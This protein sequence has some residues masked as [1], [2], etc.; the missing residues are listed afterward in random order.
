M[1]LQGLVI[2]LRSLVAVG[3]PLMQTKS[4]SA[5]DQTSNGNPNKPNQ[6]VD[7]SLHSVDDDE[8]TA[9]YRP[10]SRTMSMA[11]AI[12]DEANGDLMKSYDR[13]Q[14]TQEEIETGILKFN[15]SPKKGLAYLAS[16]GHVDHTPQGTARFFHQYVDKLDK[17]AIGD[18]LGREVEY[19]G[20]FCV[21]V[22]HEYVDMLEFENMLFDEAI[23][24]LLSGFRLPG[25]AQKI[26]RIMEKFAERYYLQNRTVFASADMAF[27]LAFSTIMLQTNLHNPAIRDDKRMTKEQF[28]RQNTGI[29]ADGELPIP[30]LSEIYDRIAAC[31]ISLVQDDKLKNKKKDE[32]MNLFLGFPV[33]VMMVSQDKRRVDAYN[34]ERK[35]MIRASEAIF[36][37]RR[38]NK[39]S[40][41]SSKPSSS[42]SSMSPPRHQLF[43]RSQGD[44]FA[45][46]TPMFEVAW[47]P[48]LSVFSQ[49]LEMSDEEEIVSL[50]LEGFQLSIRLACHCDVNT[51]RDTYITSLTKF[52][53]LEMIKE[54]KE[55]HIDGIKLLIQVALVEGDYLHETWGQILRC[56]SHLSRLQLFGNGVHSDDMFFSETP[57]NEKISLSRRGFARRSMDLTQPATSALDPF[58][59][60]STPSKAETSRL[61]E[62]TNAELLLR[63]IDPVL[64]DRIFLNSQNLST[65]SVLFFVN[66]LC[67]V[68]FEEISSSPSTG[69]SSWG[70]VMTS[71]RIFCLQKLVEVA[72]FN[73]HSRPRLAWT[74]LWSVLA[75]HFTTVGVH[76]NR[77]LSMYAIDSLKQLSIKFLQKAELSNF[78]FQR[79]FLKPFEV[80]MSRSQSSEIKELILRCLDIMVLAC[81]PNIRSGWRSIFSVFSSAAANDKQEIAGIAFEITERLMTQQFDLLIHDFV[82]LM[83][84]LVAFASGPHV[85]ISLSALSHLSQCADHLVE[86][87]VESALDSQYGH[88]ETKRNLTDTSAPPAG[89][90]ADAGSNTSPNQIDE[91]A[92]VFRL[93]WP[94]LLGLSTRVADHRL[95][96]RS[97][98]VETL[99]RVLKTYGNLFSS[100]TWEVIFKGVLFPM[101][102]S[103][104]IDD[105][106][107][108]H[109]QW[110]T[111]NPA[112]TKDPASWISTTASTALS[113][114]VNLFIQYYQQG[115]TS[116]L[117]PEL[118]TMFVGCI[119][120]EIESLSR[121]SLQILF[122]LFLQIPTSPDT[123]LLASDV[124]NL[125]A[126]KLSLIG[127]MTLK[128]DYGI[129]GMLSFDER[130]APMVKQLVNKT[131]HYCPSGLDRDLRGTT[132]VGNENG[133][134]RFPLVHTPYG[135]GKVVDEVR[136]TDSSSLTVVLQTQTSSGINMRS[137]I[138][139][140]G[141]MLYSSDPFAPMQRN[142][143]ERSSSSITAPK[144]S[145]EQAWAKLSY[146]NMSSMVL[147]LDFLKGFGEILHAHYDSWSLEDLS[148]LLG[149]LQCLYDHSRCFNLDSKLRTHLR[150]KKFMKFRDNPSRLPHLLEQETRSA[151]QIFV[152]GFRLFAE[153]NMDARGTAKAQLVEGI[154]KRFVGDMTLPSLLPYPL[155]LLFALLLE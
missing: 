120:Q 73:M 8:S 22:L 91:D 12:A 25:E 61:I 40:S 31:P 3:E 37:Q 112:L 96:I 24:L 122:E 107:Q 56:V 155:S 152:F 60:F 119:N 77:A 83:N 6:L 117:L 129:A 87:K 74:Q 4:S 108:P 75:M 49:L 113:L 35:E 99:H 104:K 5:A 58:K 134:K 21:K 135:I 103:A 137:V 126:T 127:L 92:A 102:D 138:L 46:L 11:S 142:E 15:L 151:T 109:S 125:I 9:D 143:P 64:I 146:Q 123:H 53:T 23:R 97:R 98:A 110:P 141:A 124:A 16:L 54:M 121:L 84:C 47:A 10:Y 128:F 69:T 101:I 115:L 82:E 139:S 55:K 118:I 43:L 44:I 145:K 153:E 130:T 80:I 154:L 78:N 85:L 50:C 144:L 131:Y 1:G 71:P 95:Q 133:S 149:T 76:E 70:D 148:L 105:T 29:S 30:L 88:L 136:H 27:I 65:E 100:Q 147:A 41:T 33:S 93:W 39:S 81:A 2:I 17:T 79:L 132:G 36:K 48:M 114:C 140:W 63:E 51:A 111:Q 86:G 94:L 13:K 150:S 14:R 106:P 89:A 90:D 42:S 62:E 66:N 57:G 45:Y 18:Y 7:E 67:Q 38:R 52:T 26:D 72:D 34:D 32:T 19:E 116:V 68:S 20:G 59:L 28:I